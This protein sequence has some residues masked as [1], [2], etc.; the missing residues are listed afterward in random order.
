MRLETDFFG[1]EVETWDAVDAVGIEQRHSGHVVM[2]AHSDQF[3]GQGRAFEK[4]ES[5][6][7]VKFDV[8]VLSTQYSVLS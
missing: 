3:L 5:G 6:A 2:S 1:G 8:Q 4:T 7:G